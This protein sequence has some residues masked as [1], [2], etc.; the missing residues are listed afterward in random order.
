MVEVCANDP[1][2]QSLPSAYKMIEFLTN[3]MFRDKALLA[4]PSVSI[5]NIFKGRPHLRGGLAVSHL[6]I[7]FGHRP[8]N[9]IH[10]SESISL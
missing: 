8:E 1:L 4:L 5:D 3:D 7:C 6:M 2:R 9:I 10:R